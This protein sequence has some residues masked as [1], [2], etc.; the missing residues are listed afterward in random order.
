MVVAEDL[1]GPAT[2]ILG[3]LLAAL[4][5]AN[6]RGRNPG[7]VI[8][9]FISFGI[10]AVIWWIGGGPGCAPD[11]IFQWHGAWHVVAATGLGAGLRYLRT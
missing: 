8:A 10:G 6:R 3:A 7:W 4:L 2:G 11:A 5:W 1:F 9:S